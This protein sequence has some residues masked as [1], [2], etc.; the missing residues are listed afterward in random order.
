MYSWELV[1]TSVGSCGPCV[2]CGPEIAIDPR[3]QEL[4]RKT[5]VKLGRSH[6]S[7][8]PL[9][10]LMGQVTCR[11]P[12]TLWQGALQVGGPG[13]GAAV[14]LA[15]VPGSDNRLSQQLGDE[16]AIAPHFGSVTQNQQ[17]FKRGQRMMMCPFRVPLGW[18]LAS[19]NQPQTT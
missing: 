2:W 9:P 3:G 4:G 17:N 7:A 14:S 10:V 8:L 15:A 18:S 19:W 12:G 13:L 1:K 5:G 6:V 11:G 16:V